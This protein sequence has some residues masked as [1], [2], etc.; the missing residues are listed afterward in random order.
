MAI[1]T[2]GSESR[3]QEEVALDVYVSFG[4]CDHYSDLFTWMAALKVENVA[5]QPSAVSLT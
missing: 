2:H 5:T 3:G 4:P 1:K